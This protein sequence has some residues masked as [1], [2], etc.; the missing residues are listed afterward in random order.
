MEPWL[1]K[2]DAGD[3]QAAWDLFA[4]RYRRLMLATIR[5]LVA[6][7]DDVMDFFSTVCQAL[8]AGDFTRLKQ[9]SE[10]SA[11]V[12][13]VATWLVTVVPNLTVDWLRRRDGWS[14][15]TVRP[16]S[17][18]CSTTSTPPSVSAATPTS[19]HPSTVCGL[20]PEQ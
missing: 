5:R 12:G 17:H 3:P 7:H 11:R 15:R 20:R 13:S 16:R 1:A 9:Y 18:P 2:F 19:K 14:R 6:D 8:S 4:G 10:R